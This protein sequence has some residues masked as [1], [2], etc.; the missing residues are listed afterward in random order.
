MTRHL[1]TRD[2]YLYRLERSDQG[3]L[4]EYCSDNSYLVSTQDNGQ[5]I[6]WYRGPTVP[7][8]SSSFMITRSTENS[9]DLSQYE[10]SGLR[11][12]NR[13]AFE[14]WEAVRLFGLPT[15]YQLCQDWYEN[16]HRDTDMPEWVNTTGT[17]PTELPPVKTPQPGW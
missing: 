4:V 6:K 16:R 5:T 8:L 14:G 7:A 13:N 1:G 11:A 10:P 17:P 15:N 12:P 9:N 3:I 2:R